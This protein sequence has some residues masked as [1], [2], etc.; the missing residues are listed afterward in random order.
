MA[1]RM[2][3]SAVSSSAHMTSPAA[4]RITVSP[5]V[6]SNAPRRVSRSGRFPTSWLMP[7][8]SIASRA[9]AQ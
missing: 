3:P 9:F 7:S 6:S 5:C 2:M 1:I 8:I 4:I